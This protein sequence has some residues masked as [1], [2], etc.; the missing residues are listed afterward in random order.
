MSHVLFG[1]AYYHEYQPVPRLEQDLDLMAEAGFSVIRVGESVWSTWEPENGRF[2]LDWL[3]PVLDGAHARDIAVI[4]GTPT[5]A[6]PPWLARQYPEIAGE[7]GSGRPIPWGARQEV[8]F[9]HPAFRFHADRVIRQVIGRYAGHPSVIGF[10]VD[11]EPGNE[12]LHN[13]GVFQRFVDHLRHTY[14]SVENLNRE[15][16]LTYWSHRLS[17]WADLW[18]PDGNAQPQYELAWRRFQAELT[19]EFIAWQAGIVREYATPEQFVTT[20][21]A[22]DRPAFDDSELTA[23][24]DIT[25]ANA[26]YVMQ[27]GLTLPDTRMPTQAWTTDGTWAM[28]LS[29]D[30][31]YSSR[32][33]PFLITE[34]NASHIGFSWDSRPAYDGQWR[35]AAWAHVARGA[36]M[37]G[38]WHWDTLHF[39]TETYWGGIL[40]HNGVPGRTYRELARLGAEF[41]QAGDLLA[42]LTPDAD[43]AVVLSVPSRWIMQKYPALSHPD[44]TGDERAY[45][46]LVEPFYRGAFDAGL[47]V[48]LLHAGQLTFTAEEAVRQYPVLVA[49]G[50]YLT[51]DATLDWLRA[52]AEAGGHLVIGPRT[53]YADTEAR[54]RTDRMPARLADAAGVWYDEFSN[55]PAPIEVTAE[56]GTLDLPP[57]AAATRWIDGLQPDGATVLAT[58]RH[59]H[60]GRWPAVTTRGHGRGRIT[61]VGTVP[62]IALAEALLRWAAAGRATGWPALPASV[63]C[64]GATA[65]DGR[66]LRFLHNWSWQPALV[67]APA[68]C[69]DALTGKHLPAGR[70]IELAAW[71]VRILAEEGTG[72]PA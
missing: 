27:D 35:Q 70:D 33:E 12:L 41:R 62:N 67:T 28:Y 46:G 29:A 56:P 43:I 51:D 54:A 69:R 37:I 19:S 39:G 57:G 53:G 8:D 71:D 22:Y 6:V 25:G 63:T 16:G 14:G 2:E 3:E 64:T 60:F 68:D 9:T 5:Y 26:Y 55:L 34:T 4:L 7:R 18:L 47:Q 50:L 10:Q 30:R 61:H 11:N 24:L 23:S 21:I 52:Y 66:R 36:R 44:G 32:Q 40:P 13:H 42:G 65:S 38:Y 72:Q 1:A 58:Y 49:A 59:P 45:Q 17:T 20:C 15:W 31:M 48:R